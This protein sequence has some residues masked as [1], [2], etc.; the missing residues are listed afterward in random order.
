MKVILLM[1][2][3]LKIVWAFSWLIMN[4][5]KNTFGKEKQ[6]FK[7]LSPAIFQKVLHTEAL[8][9]NPW[10]GRPSS[11]KVKSR[12]KIYRD[13]FATNNCLMK[14][15]SDLPRRLNRRL[16]KLPPQTQVARNDHV[17]WRDHWTFLDCSTQHSSTQFSLPEKS[18]SFYPKKTPCNYPQ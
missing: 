8:L 15:I 9:L 10:V 14:Q 1:I 12:M 7:N 6:I 11:G 2:H 16:M 3:D 17:T 4:L 13:D 18:S 5:I